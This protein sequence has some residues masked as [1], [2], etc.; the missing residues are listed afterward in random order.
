[1]QVFESA[2]DMRSSH[3]NIRNEAILAYVHALRSASAS[4]TA[5][6]F[7]ASPRA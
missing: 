2:V 1:M 6:C 5:A 7:S 3:G 4:K